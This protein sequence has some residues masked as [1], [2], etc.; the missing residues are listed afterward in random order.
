M[1]FSFTPIG[2]TEIETLGNKTKAKQ[3]TAEQMKT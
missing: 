3:R 2:R 1:N